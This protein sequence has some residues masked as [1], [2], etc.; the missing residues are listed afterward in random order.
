MSNV[1]TDL[2]EFRRGKGNR[3]TRLGPR[4]K[5]G[6]SNRHSGERK[7]QTPND[8]AIKKLLKLLDRTN[9]KKSDRYNYVNLISG[10]EQIR[11]MNMPVLAEV[12]HYMY[13]VGNDVNEEN[14]NYN[15]ISPYIDKLLPEKEIQ[16]NE[17]KLR[18]IPENELTIIKLRLAATFVRY[19]RYV[20]NLRN[21]S[22]DEMKQ[23]EQI[24]FTIDE[25]Q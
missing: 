15:A 18:E 17:T 1:F 14:L 12:F 21:Q 22:I 5:V 23:A 19:I 24:G 3:K 25:Y 13:N 6:S 8:I 2:G 20:M 7:T 9:I 10:A 16:E 4:I 11:F